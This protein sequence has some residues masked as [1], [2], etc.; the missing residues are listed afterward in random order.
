MNSKA[1][2]VS[3]WVL[4]GLIAV[5]MIVLS[6]YGKFFDFPGKE[7]MFAKMGWSIDTMKKIGVVEVLVTLLFILPRVGFWG[8]ILLTAYLGGASAAHVRV[9][10]APIFPIVIG[11]LTWIALGLR[12]PVIFALAMGRFTHPSVLTRH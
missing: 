9:G 12:H 10:E 2:R 7:E 6:S 1:A 8:A 5:F 4:S 3:G 11:V